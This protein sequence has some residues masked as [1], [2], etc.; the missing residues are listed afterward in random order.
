MT[1]FVGYTDEYLR[2]RHP[3]GARI[4]T[5]E[6]CPKYQSS[7][8]KKQYDRIC[9]TAGLLSI[10][11]LIIQFRSRSL[12]ISHEHTHSVYKKSPL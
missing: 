8:W 1:S 5:V 4:R 10:S 11:N 12:P 9:W 7:K 6:L 2:K 3:D